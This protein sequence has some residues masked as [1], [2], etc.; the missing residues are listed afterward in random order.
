[1]S[2]TYTNVTIGSLRGTD[3]QKGIG[4]THIQSGI[5]Y[6]STI[7]HW[8]VTTSPGLRNDVFIIQIIKIKLHYELKMYTITYQSY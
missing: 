5:V 1:M 3:I 7:K 6:T 8:I 4:Y 2:I